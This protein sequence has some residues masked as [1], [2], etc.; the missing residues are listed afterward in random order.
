[1][2]ATGVHKKVT[3][4]SIPYSM[5]YEAQTKNLEYLTSKMNGSFDSNDEPLYTCDERLPASD[6]EVL[7]FLPVYDAAV[8]VTSPHA[9]FT[10]ECWDFDVTY[11]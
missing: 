1:M 10:G 3:F 8:N 5:D 6:T 4:P 7:M 2:T 9:T 11:E